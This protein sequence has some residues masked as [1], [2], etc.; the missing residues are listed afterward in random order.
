LVALSHISEFQ[1]LFEKAFT[2]THTHAH[3]MS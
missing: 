3:Y 1:N 2:H